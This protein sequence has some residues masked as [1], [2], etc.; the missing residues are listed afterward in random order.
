MR[1]VVGGQELQHLLSL[2]QGDVGLRLL[3]WPVCPAIP[4]VAGGRLPD[5][6]ADGAVRN[7]SVQSRARH[8]GVKLVLNVKDQPEVHRQQ[9]AAL[10]R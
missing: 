10:R 8:G 9:L 1:K 3:V 6:R 5:A 7:P 4:E 2:D